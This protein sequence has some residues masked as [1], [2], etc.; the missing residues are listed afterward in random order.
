MR[1]LFVYFKTKNESY[2][3][4]FL[5]IMFYH[6]CTFKLKNVPGNLSLFYFY[7]FKWNLLNALNKVD[8]IPGTASYLS[9]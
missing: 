9:L 8:K 3:R 4:T 7:L 1:V 5:N 2:I 6:T